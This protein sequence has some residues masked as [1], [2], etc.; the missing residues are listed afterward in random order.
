VRWAAHRYRTRVGKMINLIVWAADVGSVRR[1]NFGWC[2]A[3]WQQESVGT[4]TG[5]DIL[6]FASGVT[7]DLSD[8]KKVAI[9]FECPLFVPVADDPLF[10]TSARQGDGN[11]A[12]SAFG[13]A[14]A[15][16]TGL[17]E[18]VWIFEK[19]RLLAGVPIQ[20]TFSW[21]ELLSQEANLF[22]WEAF[23]SGSSKASSHRRDAE[24][25]TRTFWAEYPEIAKANAVT[26][27]NPYSLVG[28][29]LLRSGLTTDLSVLSEQCIVIKSQ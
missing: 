8:G 22:I 4:T 29:A 12:W 19:I 10:L 21:Q 23:V 16:A 28:A 3:S 14:A 25:A 26:A 17:A 5:T 9:G 27:Q 7:D 24:T 1:N 13:G 2:R 11:R 20:P 18:C 15:L 6:A